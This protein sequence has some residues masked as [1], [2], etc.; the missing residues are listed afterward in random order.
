M[1]RKST[2]SI[3][4][5]LIFTMSVMSF[6][7]QWYDCDAMHYMR[8]GVLSRDGFVRDSVLSAFNESGSKGIPTL[9][10]RVSGVLLSVSFRPQ[11]SLPMLELEVSGIFTCEE[12][13][14]S[15]TAH[16]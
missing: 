11:H 8:D 12:L 4:S 15:L 9:S 1:T 7:G 10:E 13:Q 2:P 3:L 16:P 6:A 14:V 5:I